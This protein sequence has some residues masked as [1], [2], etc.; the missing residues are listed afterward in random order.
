[1]LEKFSFREEIVFFG[2]IK[3]RMRTLVIA[4]KPSV[5][6][7]IAAVLG[8]MKK[9]EDH[10]ENEDYVV[11]SALGHLVELQMPE[12]MDVNLKRWTLKNLPILPEK[13]Q[14]KSSDK[15]KDRFKSLSK[16]LKSR[17]IDH[18]INAC[19]SGREGELIFTYIYELSGSKKPYQRLWMVSMTPDGIRESFAHLRSAEEMAPLQSAARCRSEADWLVGINGTRAVTLRTSGGG[20][21]SSVGRV[22]TPTLSLIVQRDRTI[23]NFVPVDYWRI[24]GEF[25]LRT[26]DYSGIYTRAENKKSKDKNEDSRPDR[27]FDRAEVERIL[28]EIQGETQALVTDKKKRTK[29]SPPRLYDLTS[30]QRDANTRFHYSAATTLSIAQALYDTHKAITYPRTDAKALPEDYGEVCRKTLESLGGEYVPLAQKVLQIHKINSSDRKIFNNKDISDHFAIIP[31]PMAPAKTLSESEH[32]IYDMIV[33]R[34]I[35]VFYPAAEHDVTTR[36]SSVDAHQFLSGG[37]VLVEAGWLE[38]FDRS[39]ETRELLPK[40]TA[41]D[42]TP[43]MATIKSIDLLAEKTRPPAHYTEA[44]LLSAMETAGRLVEDEELSEAMGGKGLGTPATRAQI[45]DNL[46]NNAYMNRDDRAL[47]CTT[48]AE[49]LMDFLSA[50]GIDILRD[51]ALTGEWEFKLREIEMRQF[52]REEFMKEIELLT[53]S[54]TEKIKN[55]DE[56]DEHHCSPSKI[57]SPLDEKPLLESFR[58]YMTAD[59]SIFINKI[60][61]GR[62]LADDEVVKLLREGRIGPFDNFKSRAGKAFKASIILEN[63]R[64]KIEFDSNSEESL[65]AIKRA[66]A[67]RE[68]ASE[69]GACPLHCGGKIIATAGAFLCENLANRQCNFRVSR[70]I[71]GRE[72]LQSEL[73][74][75]LADGKTPL[76]EGFTSNRTGKPFSAF[77][78]LGKEGKINFEFPPREPRAKPPKS[79][80]SS[81]SNS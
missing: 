73:E 23:R 53:Q 36:I 65:E 16:W 22:Q 24:S 14:L 64:S 35:A 55:F 34:F 79:K 57:I 32:K 28:A 31:T 78:C 56:T 69:V 61:G 67:D 66:L 9:V 18:I 43:P 7:D 39:Q 52:S 37:K 4:E 77:L 51:P 44:T 47:K 15:T 49:H 40:I 71:L 26:G 20:S 70:H 58:S 59:K 12:D 8:A 60:L 68:N 42:G 76:L 62:E 33:R 38:V 48:K 27:F 30:L 1:M 10:F 45:I 11:T 21:V 3:R 54:M 29:Q 74:T 50:M 19:D 46:V 5:A 41:A 6:K 17:E 80:T 75:L 2:K 72:I 25:S 13:F 63:G 81:P